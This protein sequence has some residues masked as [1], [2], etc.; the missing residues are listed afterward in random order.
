MWCTHLTKLYH[1][2][3]LF[4]HLGSFNHRDFVLWF[5]T[6]DNKPQMRTLSS[7]TGDIYIPDE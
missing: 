7:E 6:L 2:G 5:A 4:D 1:T 3:T